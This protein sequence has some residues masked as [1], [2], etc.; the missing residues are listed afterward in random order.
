MCRRSQVRS[1]SN[2]SGETVSWSAA[3]HTTSRIHAAIPAVKSGVSESG[4]RSG[5]PASEMPSSTGCADSRFWRAMFRDG[6]RT[7]AP[8]VHES[9][10]ESGR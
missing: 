8:V 3:A 6:R 7:L 2:A 9:L 1:R 10:H 5:R 4:S